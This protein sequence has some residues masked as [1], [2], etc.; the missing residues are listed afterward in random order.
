MAKSLRFSASSA[1]G[2]A[3]F[4]IALFAAGFARAQDQAS[5]EVIV[6]GVSGEIRNNVLTALGIYQERKSDTLAA[7]RIR[8]LHERAGDEIRAALQ[9]YGYYRPHIK[10]TLNQREGRW[11]AHYYIDPGA[12]VT[13][14]NV[15]VHVTGDAADDPEFA[16]LIEGFPLKRGDPLN[17]QRYE[18][19]KRAFQRT[20]AE[21]G[22]FDQRLTRHEIVVDLETSYSADVYLH[23]DSGRRFRFGTVTLEQDVL[24][25]AFLARYVR[26]APGQPYSTAALLELQAALSGSDYFSDVDVIADPEQAEGYTIPVRVRLTPRKPNK[27]TFGIGYGTD[28]GPRGQIGWERRYLNDEGH[29][30]R[31]EL[32]GSQIERAVTAGYFIPIRNPRTDQLAFTASYTETDVNQTDTEV[33]RIGVSRTTQRG[34]LQETLSLTQQNEKFVIGEQSGSSALLIPGV[35]WSHFFGPDRI[36]TRAGSRT[37]LDLR[38]ASEHVASDTSLVQARLQTKLILPIL[39]FGRFIARAEAGTTRIDDFNK[40]P[41]SLRFFA[42]GDVSVRGYRYNSL[43]PTDTNGTVIGG[44]S[45]LVGSLEYEQRITGNWSAA[46]FHDV[47]NA[48]NDFSDPLQKGVGLGLRY[49]TPVGQIRV[50]VA[51]ARSNPEHPLRLHISIGPDL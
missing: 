42:G 47:G 13:V 23:M 35:T 18:Q 27:Y 21:R 38:G 45:L 24:D 9:P 2:I 3:A 5:L 41:P 22:Y 19:A 7:A 39:E 16:K 34:R 37:S 20:A 48:L 10:A 36:Y 51:Q 26:L 32:R 46:L 43:G 50:D 31:T 4:A 44:K 28:T 40:L 11:V 17:H 15:D 6:E 1:V 8:R 33:R 25:P 49:R 30:I 12:A 14:A 29:H